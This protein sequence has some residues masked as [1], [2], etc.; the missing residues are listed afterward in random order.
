[1]MASVFSE[2]CGSVKNFAGGHGKGKKG[3]GGG[4]G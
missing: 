3:G 4:G 2:E 1:M